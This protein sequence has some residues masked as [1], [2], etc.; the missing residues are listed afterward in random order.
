MLSHGYSHCAVCSVPVCPHDTRER[1]IDDDNDDNDNNNE[2]FAY[3]KISTNDDN[4]YLWLMDGVGIYEEH[5]SG[6]NHKDKKSHIDMD[7]N[8]V[9]DV[10]THDAGL[11]G[12]LGDRDAK[13]NH[14]SYSNIQSALFLHSY[15]WERVKMIKDEITVSSLWWFLA[16]FN[17]GINLVPFE[18]DSIQYHNNVWMMQNPK[19]NDKNRNRIDI[20]LKKMLQSFEK[21]NNNFQIDYWQMK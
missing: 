10:V 1:S 8:V 4:S 14:F 20:K 5:C 15:C 9:Y 21:W 11:I 7:G 6:K 12:L 2:K 17:I 3:I 18:D 19:I 13:I 16:V